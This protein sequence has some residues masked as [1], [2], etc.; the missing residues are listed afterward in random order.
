MRGGALGQGE[1][2]SVDMQKGR[3]RRDR[4]GNG[5]RG[6][7]GTIRGKGESVGRGVGCESLDA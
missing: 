6:G 7:V 2:G 1:V 4:E 3:G 5:W